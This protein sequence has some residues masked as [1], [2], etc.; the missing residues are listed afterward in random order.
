MNPQRS[1][2]SLRRMLAISLGLSPLL[3]IPLA[4]STALAIPP[5]A[6]ATTSALSRA[7]SP[8]ASSAAQNVLNSVSCAGTS[9]CVSVGGFNGGIRKQGA[10]AEYWNG[11]DWILLHT[12]NPSTGALFD[13]VSCTSQTWC[14][15]VGTISSPGDDFSSTLAEEWEGG[16]WIILNAPTPPG[17]RGFGGVSC[18]SETFCTAVGFEDTGAAYD[19]FAETW[20]GSSWTVQSV[21]SPKGSKATNLLN[22]SCVSDVWCIAVGA[23][24][25]G[26]LAELWD[27]TSWSIQSTPNPSGDYPELADVSCSSTTFCAAVAGGFAETWDGST[28]TSEPV[29]DPGG[30]PDNGLNGVSCTS[31]T[32]CTAVGAYTNS[33]GAGVTLAEEWDGSAWSAQSPSNPTHNIS[34][35]LRGVSCTAAGS[36]AAVG[37]NSTR[38]SLAEQLTENAWSIFATP[39]V[40]PLSLNPA[41]GPRITP[42]AIAGFGFSPGAK[43]TV[44]YATKVGPPV[45]LCATV[46]DS[47][48]AYSCTG[49]IPKGEA[50]PKGAHTIAAKGVGFHWS[51]RFTLT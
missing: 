49:T 34:S 18:T 9:S 16:S 30:S 6:I 35:D 36:C 42:I 22:V 44:V 8:S 37:A 1:S 20:D 39:S 17:T 10:L 2:I 41:Q 26:T 23:S 48:G 28:W 27:G 15:A 21:P 24:G 32:S 29:L 33:S 19:S 25:S 3:A 4:T 40:N 50:G 43:V 14:M 5:G 12:P 31:S 47:Q 7:A 45:T 13:S 11:D 46:A 51:T 38:K